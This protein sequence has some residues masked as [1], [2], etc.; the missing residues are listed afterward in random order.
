M[1]VVRYEDLLDK[2]KQIQTLNKILIFTE[3]EASN[4]RLECAFLLADTPNVHRGKNKVSKDFM[5][6]SHENII[7]DIWE[8]VKTFAEAFNYKV[9]NGTSCSV[10]VPIV[11]E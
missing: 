2:S 6:G 8:D 1:L 3:F 7:C 4:A 9:F 11:L 5:Y 10:Q